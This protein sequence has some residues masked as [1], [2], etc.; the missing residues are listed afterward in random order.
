MRADIEMNP[1]NKLHVSSWWATS[2]EYVV[3]ALRQQLKAASAIWPSL[4][5]Y[6]IVET[7]QARGQFGGKARAAALP[8]DRRSEIAAKAANTRWGKPDATAPHETEAPT[9]EDENS[10]QGQ[11]QGQP[12]ES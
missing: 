6:Q 12:Q 9:G 10:Q 1:E 4:S 7:H 3:S 2:P 11:V 5:M 8:A